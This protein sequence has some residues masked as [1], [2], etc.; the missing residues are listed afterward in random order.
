MLAVAQSVRVNLRS[1]LY[2]HLR[3]L[4]RCGRRGRVHDHRLGDERLF[5][6]TVIHACIFTV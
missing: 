4:R 5:V 3:L 1:R 2:C 6:A